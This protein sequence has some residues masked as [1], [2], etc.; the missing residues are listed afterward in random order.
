MPQWKFV[1]H[2]KREHHQRRIERFARCQKR[3]RKWINFGE[4]AEWCAAE[5]GSIVVD[6]LKEEVAI[7]TLK[8]DVL[9]GEF[10]EH[11]R[12]LVLMLHPSQRG[13]VAREWARDAVDH[14]YDEQ[15]GRAWLKY[16]WIPR[17][18]F[19]RWLQK[20]RLTES[21]PRFEPQHRTIREVARRPATKVWKANLRETLTVGE[22]AIMAAIT[23]LWPHGDL[24]QKAKARNNKINRWLKERNRSGLSPRTIN[25]ALTTISFR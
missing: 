24:G 5:R 12:S 21:A 7:D 8:R 4:I 18:M 25:R 6:E 16:C 10:E 3:E 14:N 2:A 23:N 22:E 11:D 15:H 20:H 17:R 1:D 9:D 19:Q 13:R